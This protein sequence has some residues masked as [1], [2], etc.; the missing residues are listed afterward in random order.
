[1]DEEYS[2]EGDLT[3]QEEEDHNNMRD[4]FRPVSILE[5]GGLDLNENE[6]HYD[7]YNLKATGI[8]NDDM[9]QS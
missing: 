7:P 1:M 3:M 2:N 4:T 5:T 8:N 9:R 6:F